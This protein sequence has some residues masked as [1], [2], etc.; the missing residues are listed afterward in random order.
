MKQI[1]AIKDK[2]LNQ[3]VH[4]VVVEGLATAERAF[5][6][7]VNNPETTWHQWPEDFSLH[8]LGSIDDETGEIVTTFPPVTIAEASQVIMKEAE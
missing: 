3:Y 4:F 1:T 7:N 5:T 6:A 2:K 8:V